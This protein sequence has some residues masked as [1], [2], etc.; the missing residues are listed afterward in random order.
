MDQSADDL[1][2]GLCQLDGDRT[3]VDGIFPTPNELLCYQPV[4]NACD[5]ATVHV[6]ILRQ[7]LRRIGIIAIEHH[8]DLPLRDRP[9]VLRYFL[10]DAGHYVA[11]ETFSPIGTIILHTAV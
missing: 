1:A 2:A 4:D 5:G 8:Q 9:S 7:G 11:G 3:P 10:V 6:D